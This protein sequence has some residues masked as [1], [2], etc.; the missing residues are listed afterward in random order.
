MDCED[1]VA[2]NKKD[3]ARE[4]IR[5]ILDKGKPNKS[6]KYDWGVRANSI[7]SGLCEEDLKS[8]LT[9][10]NLPDTVL[11]PKVQNCDEI[12]WFSDKVSSII[13]GNNSVNLIIYIETAMSFINLPS[14]CKTAVDLSKNSKFRPCALVYGGDDFVASIGA[15]KTE[16]NTETLYARQ[17]L[18]LVAKAYNLQAIDMVYIKYKDLEGLKKQSE[19]GLHMGFTGKQVIH[20]GQ[21]PVVQNAFLPTSSQVEWAQGLLKSFKEHQ[22]T[23]KGAFTYRGSMIDMP[24]MK[25]AQNIIEIVNLAQK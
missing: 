4:T 19:Q 10:K 21:V 15:I 14:I 20:P 23:G 6:R 2:I 8:L 24:T 11:L 3:V 18:V 22:K 1:G 12:K 7:D 17:K 13:S 5:G 9:A 16:E 25:Q